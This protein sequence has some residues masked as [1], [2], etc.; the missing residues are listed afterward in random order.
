MEYAFSRNLFLENRVEKI[1]LDSIRL[2]QHNCYLG[3]APFHY[4]AAHGDHIGFGSDFKKELAIQKSIHELIERLHFKKLAAELGT[5]NTTG[6]A[7]HSSR[8]KAAD[9]SIRELIERDSVISTWLLKYPPTWLDINV[10]AA[11]LNESYRKLLTSMR[12]HQ[13]IIRIG[14][15]SV[16]GPYT[17]VCS[18][19]CDGS[20]TSRFGL[21]FSSATDRHLMTAI[22]STLNELSRGAEVLLHR[23]NQEISLF[24]VNLH[25][26]EIRDTFQHLEFYLNPENIRS[27]DWFLGETRK[28][29]LITPFHEP[30]IV[31][32]EEHF[33]T[34][35][36]I[37]ASFAYS[38][39]Y[40]KFFTGLPDDA[41]INLERLSEIA[42]LKIET[43]NKGIHYLP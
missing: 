13:F 5:T 3:E 9:A 27:L 23:L 12:D 24:D 28:E 43:Y 15:V 31:F 25:P 30:E 35:W 21:I 8:K 11:N 7:V 20:R 16:T 17:T 32:L 37:S 1:G 18:V 42:D 14:V 26:S 41:D 38:D 34:P 29:N 2:T 36:P 39:K 33:E 10:A 40:Q 4:S 6:F 22:T 19:L